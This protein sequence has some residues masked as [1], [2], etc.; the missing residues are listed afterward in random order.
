[1]PRF[2]LF[3]LLAALTLCAGCHTLRVRVENP[4]PAPLPRGVTETQRLTELLE[5]ARTNPANEAAVIE[6]IRRLAARKFDSPD[7]RLV[8][9]GK[10]VLDP[11]TCTDL[12]P[13]RDVRIGGLE[14]R[15]TQDGIGVPCVAYFKKDS[16]ALAGQ[17][18]IAPAGMA[19][20][21]TAVLRFDTPRPTLCF[22][23]RLQGDSAVIDGRRVALAGDFSAPIAVVLSH[24]KNRSI[25]VEAMLF[26]RRNY[27]QMGLYQFE[28]YDP[29]KIPVVFVH[30][31]LSR[32]EAWV[33]ALNGLMADPQIRARYQFW[34]YLYPTG[35]PVWASAA[36]LRRELDRFQRE[37]S[38]IAP[39]PKLKQMVLAGHSMGG[40]ICSMMIREG[41]NQLWEQF[42]DVPAS[43]LRLTPEAKAEFLR[44]IYFLPR[45]DVSRVIFV[46]TPHR[47]SRLALRPLAGFV[48]NL[49]Q[50]PLNALTPYRSQLIRSLREDVRGIF[51]SPANSI[52]FLRANSPLLLSILKLPMDK[53]VPFHTILGDRGRGNSPN[54]TDGVVPYWSSHLDG[55]VSEKVVPSGHGANEN[56]QGVEEI[57]RILREN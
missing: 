50:L 2:A 4:R 7:I 10:Q 17:P 13:A 21:V 40:L 42:S 22:Y 27:S 19:I 49:I 34:F 3:P 15:S 44:F 20:P 48:A 8:R 31:L 43:Q 26:S 29:K 38:A 41:G 1:M 6:I 32:P 9:T 39:S 24:G 47:G 11:T 5:T 52:R 55:A 57:R 35:L 25:D 30:G 12:I 51:V 46:A 45:K 14:R 16:P 33:H 23:T 54:S 53:D 28:P 18:G 37:C 56:P 36:G